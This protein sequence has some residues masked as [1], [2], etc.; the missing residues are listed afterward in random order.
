M[1]KNISSLSWRQGAEKPLFEQYVDQSETLGTLP[2]KNLAQLA[3]DFLIGNSSVLGAASFYDFLKEENTTKKV[4][5]CNGSACLTAET[6]GK[7][8]DKLSE[9]FNE[10]EIGQMCCL[11]RC[12]ENGAFQ[13]DGMN[14]S[15]RSGAEMD[16]IIAT[17]K[18][19]DGR[20][21]YHIGSNLDRP[22]LTGAFSGVE[23]FYGLLKD[24]LKRSP[25]DLLAELIA[26]NLRGR[27]GAGFPAGIKWKTCR[28]VVSD[29]KFIVCNADE[30]DPGAYTDRYLLEKQPHLVLFGML[31]AGYLTNAKTGVLYIRAE[32][33]ESVTAIRAAVDELES[34][35][36]V[37]EGICGSDFDFRFKVIKGAGAYICGEETA[38]LA[39]I[40]GQRP[41]VRVRPPFPAI[42]GL[43][44]K[45]T[46]VNNVETF[47]A[48]HAV[49]EM[50]GAAFAKIGRGKSTGSKLVSLDRFFK[51][52][53]VYEI[54]MG[55][56]LS[57]VLYEFGGGFTEPI[58]ALHIGGP[59]GGLV[60][61]EKFE[62]LTLDFESF[63]EGGFLLGHGSIICIPQSFPIIKYIE[64]LFEFTAAESCGKCFPCRLGSVRGQE[65]MEKAWNGEYIIDRALLVDLIET[66]EE[67]SL[68][69]LGGGVPLP[70]RNA[71]EYFDGELKTYFKA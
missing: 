57:D 19:V 71:L 2:Q 42:E 61:K 27:G 41:E 6:Q 70:I 25:D 39:S 31:L 45:P 16:A 68:C 62:D 33:P 48:I 66:L 65:M 49:Y 64:H 13:Y 29:T 10:D 35:G 38:L 58:K 51:K 43:Y 22:I 36:F 28:E 53:G 20:D 34:S 67:G 4:Y 18:K 37:G 46:V 8:A 23:S 24:L 56:P 7:L 52:P 44:R 63:H 9:H 5:V 21:S 15:A 40:E 17:D 47:A 69:A 26:S 55:T 54:K 50:G 60:P 3:K 32:Y 12:H 30:G 11:G 1:S 14:Y 59:L